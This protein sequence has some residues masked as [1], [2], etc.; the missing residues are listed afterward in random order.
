MDT[1][2]QKLNELWAIPLNL[3]RGQL[4]LREWRRYLPKYRR[5]LKQFEDWSKSGKIC[6]LLRNVLPSYWKNRVEDEEKKR[7]KKHMAVHI[8]SLEEQLPGI[9][10]YF[11]RNLGAR[12]RMISLKNSVYVVVF[13]ETA[14]ER[15]VQLNNA[16][17][18][19]GKS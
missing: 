12:E 9:M 14:A 2:N 17:W 4:L 7:T 6:H 1:P 10:E 11:R 19:R 5:L 13:G 3:E 15:L 18:R 8:M 16:E